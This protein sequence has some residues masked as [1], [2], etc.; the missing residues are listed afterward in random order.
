MPGTSEIGWPQVITWA[1]VILGWLLVNHQ[2]NLREKRK[3]VRS[4]L[5]KTQ[6]LLDSIEA[7]A[8]EYHTVQ[9]TNDLAFRIKRALSQ[10]IKYR[11]EVLH[12]RSLDLGSCNSYLKEL[13]RAIT[14]KNFDSA[15][16]QKIDIS[17]QIVKGIWLSKD[18][19]SQELERCFSKKYR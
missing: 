18:R 15:N 13:R 12:L 19:L 10:K 4:L 2:N 3:E 7:Q 1:L 5:D 11:L 17:D 16:Y 14:L 8:I 6:E 9:E